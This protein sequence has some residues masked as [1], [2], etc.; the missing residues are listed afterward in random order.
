L[1]ITVRGCAISMLIFFNSLGDISSL[2]ADLS[3]RGV[4]NRFS[5]SSN[6]ISTASS[7]SSSS[8]VAY[9]PTGA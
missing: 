6:L 2:P 1:K 7:S 8:S 3:S 4:D 9:S 5:T